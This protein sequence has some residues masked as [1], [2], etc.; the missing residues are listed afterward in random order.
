YS[1]GCRSAKDNEN[2]RDEPHSWMAVTLENVSDAWVRQVTAEHFAGSAVAVMGTAR[3]I[4][5]EYCKYLSR[6]SEI[7][8]QRR[9][10]FFTSGGQTLF[11]R[12][13]S[14]QAFHDFSV[15]FC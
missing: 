1:L 10:A 13:Y 15:G 12:L 7:G 6:V 2:K 11:Q 5:V 9:N 3:R 4:T 8:G 14:E